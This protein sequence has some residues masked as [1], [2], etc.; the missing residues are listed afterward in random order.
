MLDDELFADRHR[1]I[2]PRGQRPERAAELLALERHPRRHPAALRQLDR[3]DDNLL[4]AALLIDADDL[5]N[6]EQV[7]RNRHRLGADYDMAVQH[8]LTRLRERTGKAE[9]I[10]H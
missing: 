4:L 5:T 7:R 8:E 3:L 9:P 2:R 10:D 1:E 6:L